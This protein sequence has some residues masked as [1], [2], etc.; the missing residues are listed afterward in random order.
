MAQPQPP[1]SA[2]AISAA[3]RSLRIRLLLAAIVVASALGLILSA[4][5]ATDA[6]LSI[7][8]RLQRL[9]LWLGVLTGGFV[10]ALVLVTGW[11]LWRLLHPRRQG[12]AAVSKSIDRPS[13]EARIANPALQGLADPL[14]AELVELDQRAA[15]EQVF[16]AL[17]GDVSAGKSSLIRAL[18]PGSEARVDVLAGTTR[19]VRHYQGTLSGGQTL[20]LADVPGTSEWHGESRAVAAREE[21]LRAHVV[22]YVCDG[23]LSR[24]QA[25][26][27]AWLGQFR[28][29]VLLLLNKSDRYRPDELAA[30][31]QRLQ[32][33]TG[34]QPLA[35]SAGGS[36]TVDVRAADGTISTR[37]RPRAPQIEPLLEALSDIARRGPQAYEK[38]RQ[39]AVLG[40]LDLKLDAIESDE[41]RRR[42]ATLVREYARKAALGAMA[43]VAPGSDLVIQ[44]VLAS[45]LLSELTQLYQVPMRSIDLDNF[46]ELAGGRLRGTSALILAI[47]GNAL[48][49]FP[50]LGTLG[51]GLIHA[52]AYAMIFDSLGKAVADTLDRGQG[53]DRQQALAQFDSSLS[54]R[55]R[56][57]QLAPDMLKLALDVR[58][59]IELPPQTR[60]TP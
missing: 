40:A 33:R 12:P 22:A 49:A 20:M 43:A 55:S 1:D 11:L 32:E 54:D 7:I 60:E 17:F 44:G 45:R 47:A 26:E 23:D 3:P 25:E 2:P 35:I 31:R 13:I 58:K 19:S 5:Y 39:H 4:I 9:P 36:E 41:R 42:A 21:A 16:V 50:G 37:E 59:E 48:K 51:G 29:P 52:V 15:L 18:V 27:L 24:T 8:E 34:V 38:G 46:I 6:A 53:F 57:L 14:K 28:K 10:S 56:L 30:L